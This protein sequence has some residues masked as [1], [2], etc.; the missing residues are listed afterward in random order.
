MAWGKN[1][2]RKDGPG[3]HIVQSRNAWIR[4]KRG[5]S[6]YDWKHVVPYNNNSNGTSYGNVNRV[7][8]SLVCLWWFDEVSNTIVDRTPATTNTSLDW[9]TAQGGQWSQDAAQSDRWYLNLSGGGQAK[10]DTPSEPISRVQSTNQLTIE[11]WVSPTEA[12]GLATSGPGR[13]IAL[14]NVNNPYS[15]QSFM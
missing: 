5:K 2:S 9:I 1:R 7:V 4:A 8:N 12:D 14:S 10:T 13:V 11:A 15:N 6:P 3:G